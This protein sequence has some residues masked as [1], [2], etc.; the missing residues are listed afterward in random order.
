MY[1]NKFVM[2][3]ERENEISL[4]KWSGCAAHLRT[5]QGTLALRA[6]FLA[7]IYFLHKVFTAVCRILLS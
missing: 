3:Q 2:L 5:L 6:F 4:C 7:V 1:D